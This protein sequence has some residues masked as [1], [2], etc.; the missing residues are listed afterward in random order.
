MSCQALNEWKTKESARKKNLFKDNMKAVISATTR[1]SSV[2]NGIVI[3]AWIGS[4]LLQIQ[5]SSC[6]SVHKFAH[7]TFASLRKKSSHQLKILWVA[8]IA[9]MNQPFL[10]PH[11]YYWVVERKLVTGSLSS[12]RF[13]FCSFL[14]HS[15]GP[16]TVYKK[17]DSQPENWE[18]LLNLTYCN[19]LVQNAWTPFFFNHLRNHNCSSIFVNG[20]WGLV[21]KRDLACNYCLIA[22]G[23]GG[24]G[25]QRP[26]LQWTLCLCKVQDILP[27]TS[28][29]EVWYKSRM[30][31][32]P[33]PPT[34]TSSFVHGGKICFLRDKIHWAYN[35][36]SILR[37]HFFL[38]TCPLPLQSLV[39]LLALNPLHPIRL[40]HP[41]R[42]IHQHSWC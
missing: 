6:F 39:A 17:P 11:I 1:K 36:E 33:S 26:S 19:H 21:T 31:E 23:G 20:F 30:P 10:Q 8:W 18:K 37:R 34:F 25:A 15:K 14:F 38:L 22:F 2:E 28:V 32:N 42:H 40:C 9:C 3:T 41:A 24:G 12:V 29:V 27:S 4:E 5:D 35:F 7:Q 16:S 13:Q